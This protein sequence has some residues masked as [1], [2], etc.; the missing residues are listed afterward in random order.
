MNP[1]THRSDEGEATKALVYVLPW[2]VYFCAFAAVFLTTGQFGFERVL[3][4]AAA[5]VMPPAI[6]GWFVLTRRS[7]LEWP[8]HDRSRF[9][10]LHIIGG[11]VFALAC[12]TLTWSMFGVETSIREGTLAAPPLVA[13]I[14]AW[15]LL[16]NLLAYAVLTVI[17]YAI[18]IEKRFREEERRAAEAESLRVQAELG[19]LR[20]RLNPH[21]LFNTLHSLLALV[22]KDPSAAE[23]A[24]EQFGDLLHYTLRVQP[25]GSGEV[26]L[27]DEWAFVQN[28]LA[29]EQL[30]QCLVML[31]RL[32]EKL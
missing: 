12:T 26:S 27:R 22:R 32:G 2:M 5:N 19:A 13:G 24:L 3:I 9:V 11:L 10:V 31:E 7:V 29:L 6:L 17:R 30:S 15:Q 21:F 4:G 8:P 16:L 20:A 25:E 23:T 28:Y 1:E 18:Q 14:V